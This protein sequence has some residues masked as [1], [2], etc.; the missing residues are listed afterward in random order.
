M[1]IAA[2]SAERAGLVVREIET[3][4]GQCSIFQPISPDRKTSSGW[5]SERS[6]NTDGWI[7]PSTMRPARRE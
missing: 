7:A 6:T 5:W 2:R 1:A 4:G 3:A